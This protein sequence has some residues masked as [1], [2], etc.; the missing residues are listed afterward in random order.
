MGEKLPHIPLYP[1]DWLRDGV[2]GCSLAAQGLWLR[3]MFVAHD[4]PV[5]GEVFDTNLLHARTNISRRCG[6][7]VEEFDELFSE[8]TE[9]SVPGLRDGIVLSRR[10]IRD[11]KLRET[12]AKAGRK[13]GK[14]T[15]KQN[16]SKRT[17]SAQANR[18]QN[19]DNDNDND[20]DSDIES[21]F[22]LFWKEYPRGRKTGK[23]AARKAFD[24]ACRKVPV[25]DLIVA[26]REYAASPLGR[27][28][29]VKGPTPWLNG[30]CWN[31]DREAWKKGDQ[32]GR[33]NDIGPGQRHDPATAEGAPVLGWA[34]DPPH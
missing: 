7:S 32:N 28:E 29:F 12:R 19:T 23:G 24:V 1:G 33:R 9:A 6:C 18:Q 20:I 21:D 26:V 2:S 31:D 16:R 14:Q 17:A 30:E 34:D 10:M 27:G 13:G 22:E 15:A 5:Y 8:L 11:G 4:A 25:G 3:M